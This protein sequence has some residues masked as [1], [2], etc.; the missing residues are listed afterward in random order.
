M[1]ELNRCPFC[2]GTKSDYIVA[3]GGEYVS[4]VLR[5]NGRVEPNVCLDCGIVY[6][7]KDVCERI[8]RRKKDG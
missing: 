5:K 2:G 1:A 6:V 3:V 7:D 8:K 4:L